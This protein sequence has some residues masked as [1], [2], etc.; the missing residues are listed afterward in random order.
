MLTYKRKSEKEQQ[1]DNTIVQLTEITKHEN[2]LINDDFWKLAQEVQIQ[3]TDVLQLETADFFRKLINQQWT[4]AQLEQLANLLATLEEKTEQKVL[5]KKAIELLELIQ[6]ESK[7]FSIGIA[8]KILFLIF[9]N[10][11]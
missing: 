7:T 6:K 8:S 1:I 10:I 11:T 2:D 4:F 9:N 5:L 3:K